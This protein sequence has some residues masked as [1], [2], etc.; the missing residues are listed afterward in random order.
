[1]E[2]PPRNKHCQ[3]LFICLFPVLILKLTTILTARAIVFWVYCYLVRPNYSYLNTIDSDCLCT[4][5][6][7]TLDVIFFFYNCIKIY[8]KYHKI[9]PFKVCS[10]VVFHLF[11]VVQLLPQPNLEHFSILKKKPCRYYQSFPITPSC[12]HCSGNH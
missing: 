1:M 3:Q 9:Y 4:E 12:P 2:P 6:T 7:H 11:R 10:S 5:G 8:L